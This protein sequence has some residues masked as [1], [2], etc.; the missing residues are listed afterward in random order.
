MCGGQRWPGH[1]NT[2]RKTIAAMAPEA[3]VTVRAEL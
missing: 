3:A 2:S 1:K